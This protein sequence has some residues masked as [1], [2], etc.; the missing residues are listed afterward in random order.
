M[1]LAF[2]GLFTIGF[3]ACSTVGIGKSLERASG[4]WTVP[5]MLAGIALGL[6]ILGP[7]AAFAA[8][9]RPQLLPTDTSMVVAL[10]IL[11]G[12][13]VGVSLAQAAFATASRG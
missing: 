6:A 5:A 13:K 3:V 8:G 1:K 10:A 7:A 2:W 4:S 9:F 11:I 12:G